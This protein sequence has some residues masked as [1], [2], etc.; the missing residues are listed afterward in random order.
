MHFAQTKSERTEKG[1]DLEMIHFAPALLY[2]FFDFRGCASLFICFF[3][4]RP[5][6]IRLTGEENEFCIYLQQT[7]RLP[8]ENLQKLSRNGTCTDGLGFKMILLI[9]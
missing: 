6:P 7:P 2:Q 8:L 1:R 9:G 4:P 3:A 5:T